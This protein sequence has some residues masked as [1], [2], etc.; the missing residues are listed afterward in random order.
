MWNM[1][2]S[3]VKI[4]FKNKPKGSTFDGWTFSIILK[5]VCASFEFV[6]Y[7]EVYSLE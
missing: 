6:L 3:S 4:T 2:I 7:A 1:T 5:I